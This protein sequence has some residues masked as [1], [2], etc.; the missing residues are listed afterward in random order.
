MSRPSTEWPRAAQPGD[1]SCDSF[2]GFSPAV[3]PCLSGYDG[4]LDAGQIVIPAM[5]EKIAGA[6]I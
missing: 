2:A 6:S 1:D 3:Q 5:A 4:G